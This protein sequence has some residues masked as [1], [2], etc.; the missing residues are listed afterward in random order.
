ME[1]QRLRGNDP[2]HTLSLTNMRKAR[3]S[4]TLVQGVANRGLNVPLPKVFSRHLDQ[5]AALLESRMEKLRS[6]N[7]FQYG[8][9]KSKSYRVAALQRFS[10]HTVTS[11][12]VT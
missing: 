3:Q 4:I 8:T 11:A 9:F 6:E 1:T 7:G 12:A 10:L 2:S 5:F